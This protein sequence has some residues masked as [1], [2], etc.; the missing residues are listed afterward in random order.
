MFKNIDI[1]KISAII[2][3]SNCLKEVKNV[4]INYDREKINSALKDFV[5]ATGINIQFLAS[6][7]TSLGRAMQ[8]NNYCAE[9]QSIKEGK[10][11][12]SC[13]DKLLLQKCSKTLKP[14]MHICHAGLTDVAIP[15][16]YEEKVIG[17]L[18]LGQMKTEKAFEDIE[19]YLIGLGL[20][21]DTMK[22]HYDSLVTFNSERIK[23]VARVAEMLSKFILLENM[24][25][26]DYN[27]VQR[28]VE[29]I[30]NNLSSPLSVELIAKNGCLSKNALYRGFKREFGLTVSKYI[31]EKRIKKAEDLLLNTELTVEDISAKV[32]FSSSAYFAAI[33][34]SKTDISPLK[35][36]KLK[37]KE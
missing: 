3:V 4:Q 28:A 29:Y 13:S 20:P 15:I 25:N 14:E 35:Y 17:Y 2:K 8:K 16:I 37:S 19:H 9:I 31:T 24:L 11:A 33:F 27:D 12:C 7:F 23:S 6:D 10:K 30:S 34:K 32:G 1:F 26:T 36:R 5:S 21:Y 22:Y 18:I